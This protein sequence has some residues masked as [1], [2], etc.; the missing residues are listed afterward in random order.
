MQACIYI[1]DLIYNYTCFSLVLIDRIPCHLCKIPTCFL[2]LKDTQIPQSGI[3]DHDPDA[4]TRSAHIFKC[5]FPM[6]PKKMYDLPAYA[7]QSD[8]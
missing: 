3:R 5:N 8:M 4:K 6:F 2:T 7:E 1:F